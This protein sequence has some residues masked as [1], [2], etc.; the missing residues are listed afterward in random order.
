MSDLDINL[1]NLDDSDNLNP[2]DFYVKFKERL[3]E[4]TS[5]PSDYSFKFIYPTKEETMNEIKEIFKN[6]NPKYDYKASKNRKYTSIS[7]EIFAT[8]ADQVILFYQE[9]AKI[10]GVIML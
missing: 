7:V 10:Q 8:D 1:Q 5:F 3:V 2:E 6:A 4:T 9:V